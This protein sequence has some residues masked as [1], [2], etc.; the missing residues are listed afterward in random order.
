MT[1]EEK[2]WGALAHLSMLAGLFLPFGNVLGPLAVYLAKKDTMPFVGDQ[3]REALNFAITKTIA[4]FVCAALTFVLVGFVLLPL[5]LLGWL[6]LMVIAAV[7]ANK[8]EAYRYPFS[9]R[10]VK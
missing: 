6:I 2:S 9:L 7:A 4:L 1:D 5:V 3:A 8:G 10:L